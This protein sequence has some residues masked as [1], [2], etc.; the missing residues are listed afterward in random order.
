[1]AEMKIEIQA[2]FGLGDALYI[3]PTLPKIKAAYPNA[4]VTV[5][6]RWPELFVDN[7]F[8]DHVGDRRVGTRLM[9][10]DPMACTGKPYL[11]PTKHNIMADWAIIAAAYRLE[12]D[13]PELRPLLYF[14]YHR[15]ARDGPIGVQV[16]HKGLYHDKKNWGKWEVLCKV[17]GFAPIP[18]C[19]TIRELAECLTSHACVVCAEGGISHLC[20]AL[21]IPCV[22]IYGGFA[23][24]AWN[25][26]KEQTNLTNFL[27][28]SPCFNNDPCVKDPP[29]QC[30]REI[31]VS[32][33]IWHAT[34]GQ[35]YG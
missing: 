19:R 9:Y 16:H 6:T 35:N 21:D 30:H 7:P 31:P 13:P 2:F 23:D 26:Y 15:G 34:F 4:H 32:E 29:K 24:P 28:C 18:H 22:V 12:L 14:P 33:V 10:R 5:N 25:G 8:V 11:K 1:M 27:D 3:T 17:S 20:R